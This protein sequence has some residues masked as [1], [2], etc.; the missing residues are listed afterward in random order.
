[1]TDTTTTATILDWTGQT[2]TWNEQ[3][4]SFAGGE[5]DSLLNAIVQAAMEFETTVDA[6]ATT[7]ANLAD[8]AT[9]DRERLTTLRQPFGHW[10]SLATDA[11]RYKERLEAQSRTLTT[12]FHLHK[13]R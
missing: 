4:V 9:R 13:N 5:G 7:L 10:T 8:N 6:L 3:V 12:L 1:M 11:D 2:V